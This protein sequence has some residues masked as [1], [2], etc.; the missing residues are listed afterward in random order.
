MEPV[1]EVL[2]RLEKRGLILVSCDEPAHFLP[3]RDIEMIELEEVLRAVRSADGGAAEAGDR[4]LS[5]PRVDEISGAVDGAIAEVL[6]GKTVKDLVLDDEDA[7][8][9]G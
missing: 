3:A 6:K 2:D 9:A 1:Q 7:E 5:L 8:P 4:Y